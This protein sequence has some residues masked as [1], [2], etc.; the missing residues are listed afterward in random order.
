MEIKTIT[1]RLLILLTISVLFSCNNKTIKQKTLDFN[2]HYWHKDSILQ[3][4]FIPKAGQ[5]YNI[6]FLVRNDN[7]YPYSNIFLIGTIEN[8]SIKTIDTLEYEMA[9]A[10]GNWL[11]NGVGEI[12]ESKLIYK[13]KYTFK[14]TSSYKISL[15]HAVRKTGNIKGDSILKGITNIGIIIEKTE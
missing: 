6:S 12:K 1:N 5:K 7:E 13:K 11:G 15:Q 8:S 10:E 3:L 2:H 9:D 4:D 14:D